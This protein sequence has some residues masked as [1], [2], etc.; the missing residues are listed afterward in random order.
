M[1]LWN[2]APN[3]SSTQCV[4]SVSLCMFVSKKKIVPAG[5]TCCH[6]AR[7]CAA[8]HRETRRSP[9]VPREE[10]RKEAKAFL[11]CSVCLS[12][13]LLV[14]RPVRAE[15]GDS[16]RHISQNARTRAKKE[17]RPLPFDPF[18]PPEDHG[19]VRNKAASPLVGFIWLLLHCC[20][21]AHPRGATTTTPPPTTTRLIVR[22][23]VASSSFLARQRKRAPITH[24][25]RTS[26]HFFLRMEVSYVS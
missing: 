2:G 16:G 14:S 19:A 22:P 7:M 23:S 21:P 18:F 17:G 4:A 5:R 3:R 6:D 26:A 10:E 8:G 13:Y 11:R 9:S 20:W 25:A 1:D 24:H 15:R 12:V